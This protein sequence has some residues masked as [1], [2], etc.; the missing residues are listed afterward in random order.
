MDKNI[1][2]KDLHP[3]EL[4]SKEEIIKNK[5]WGIHLGDYIFWDEEKQLEWIRDLYGWKETE[6]EGT[7]K[8]Y[9]STECITSGMHDFTCYLKREVL[10]EQ[11]GRPY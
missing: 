2:A 11:L 5:V 4:P 1:T 7:Y 6:M 10:V 8:G 9:K 3:F